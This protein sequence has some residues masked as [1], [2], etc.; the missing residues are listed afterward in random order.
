MTSDRTYY[1]DLI[2]NLKIKPLY[3]PSYLCNDVFLSS[4]KSFTGHDKEKCV[5]IWNTICTNRND[6]NHQHKTYNSK[7]SSNSIPKH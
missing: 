4:C 1:G 2:D 7:D 5:K 6:T 3:N